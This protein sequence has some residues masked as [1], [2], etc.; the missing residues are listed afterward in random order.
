MPIPRWPANRLMTG[1]RIIPVPRNAGLL[2]WRFVNY[3]TQDDHVDNVRVTHHASRRL[4]LLTE[5][6]G[7]WLA[8][9]HVV[10]KLLPASPLFFTLLFTFVICIYLTIIRQ[11]SPSMRRMIVLV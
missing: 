1:R 6:V 8:D 11:Y 7:S 9:H 5:I 4:T 2:S 10:S 3:L